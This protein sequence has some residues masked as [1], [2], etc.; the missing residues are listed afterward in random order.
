M[1]LT[2][3]RLFLR[4]TMTTTIF[5]FNFVDQTHKVGIAWINEEGRYRSIMVDVPEEDA[6]ELFKA[7]HGKRFEDD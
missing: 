1:K 2:V 4:K 6:L 3:V 7:T 5:R